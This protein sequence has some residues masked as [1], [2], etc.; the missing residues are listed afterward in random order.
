[1]QQSSAQHRFTVSAL[2]AAM[3][4]G[5]SFSRKEWPA[6]VTV[7]GNFSADVPVDEIA[8]A[9][10][11]AGV[12][13]ERIDIRCD[14]TEWFGPDHDKPVQLVLPERISTVHERLADELEQLPGFTADD[15]GFWREGYR[16]HLTL[17]SAISP[18]A[19]EV[20]QVV[21]IS[22]ARLCGDR[23]TNDAAF[24]LPVRDPS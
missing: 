4:V 6:H 10:R 5:T 21:Q 11:R 22:V 12:L 18:E 8:L 16:P 2:F 24:T 14:G 7:A 1:M 23:A 13:T 19:G 9:V 3:P 15:P 17:G 20:K